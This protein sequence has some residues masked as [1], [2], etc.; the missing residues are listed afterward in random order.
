M[1][2]LGF[3]EKLLTDSFTDELTNG[4][5][6]SEDNRDCPLPGS[7]YNNLLV[8]KMLNVISLSAQFSEYQTANFEALLIMNDFL[9][10]KKSNFNYDLMGSLDT[11]SLEDEWFW[12]ST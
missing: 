8:E 11:A 2:F 10:S 12:A 6:P 3:S 7:S 5:G 9:V 1:L 4:E